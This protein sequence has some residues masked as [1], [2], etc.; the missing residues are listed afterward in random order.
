MDHPSSSHRNSILKNQS[1]RFQERY[2]DPVAARN[3]VPLNQITTLP[4]QNMPVQYSNFFQPSKGMF[5]PQQPI[6]Y[7]PM[8]QYYRNNLPS[9]KIVNPNTTTNNNSNN[10]RPEKNDKPKQSAKS[11]FKDRK[12]FRAKSAPT[13]NFP[14]KHKA[15]QQKY[16]G[17]KRKNSETYWV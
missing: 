16:G 7:V 17:R 13:K 15:N 3:F 2:F 14:H 1:K 10:H 11:L 8:S 4:F 9:M 6:T 5:L 12:N